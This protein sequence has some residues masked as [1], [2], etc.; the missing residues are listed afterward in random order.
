[1]ESEKEVMPAGN[2]KTLFERAGKHPVLIITSICSI[3]FAII[4]GLF[5]FMQIGR[6]ENGILE[7]CAE[8]QDAYVQ[9]VLDQINL[10]D[11]R[12]D[13][14]II[15]DILGAMDASSN[16]YWTF[17]KDQSMLFVKD[18]TE[19]NKYKGVNTATYYISD[20]A[21]EFLNNLSV[22]NVI[23]SYI[24]INDNRYIASGV[25]FE[26]KGDAYRLCLLTE[27]DVLLDNNAYLGVRTQ[28]Q[29]F[30]VVILLLLVV[31]P[32]LFAHFV[33]KMQ[34]N[35]DK[36]N[37]SLLTI[38]TIMSKMSQKL[39]ESD[40][41]DTRNNMWHEN[42][43]KQFFE[44]IKKRNVYPVTA[45]HIGCRDKNMRDEFIAKA[46]YILDKN[47]LRF[48]YK[49]SDVILIFI[50]INEESA[51]KSVDLLTSEDVKI[52]N[53]VLVNQSTGLSDI[54]G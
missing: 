38:N 4:A 54:T 26:Y 15:K 46:H 27:K 6:Y 47:V 40:L 8:Q 52:L 13:E 23:H 14:Q 21:K 25:M 42:V 32:M 53:H 29:T 34:F 41:H 45:I 3:C 49:D 12:D 35:T 43:L 5:A 22:N 1:M 50:K 11:N 16:R 24:E 17:S 31:V 10:K 30:V 48:E 18:V 7:V 37:E 36:L 33:R 44:K 51:L 9:L 28:M 19:T 39:T 2:K 20:S